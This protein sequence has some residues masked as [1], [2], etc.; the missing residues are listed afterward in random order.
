LT[1]A[2]L[3]QLLA[4]DQPWTG[5]TIHVTQ[6]LAEFASLGQ[7][8]SIAPLIQNIGTNYYFLKIFF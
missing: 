2:H 5:R 8:A 6:T 1:P 4:A 7:Y 3:G